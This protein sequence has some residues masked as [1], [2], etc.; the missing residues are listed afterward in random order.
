MYWTTA[1]GSIRRAGMDGSNQIMIADTGVRELRG[2]TIDFQSSRL[3][4]VSANGK[5]IQP[6]SMNGGSV[7]T[8]LSLPG[9][10]WPIGIGIFGDRIYWTDHNSNF[11]KSCTKSGQDVQILHSGGGSPRHL[12]I[13]PALH[14]PTARIKDC[15]NLSCTKVCVLSPTSSGCLA[16]SVPI[17]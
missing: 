10:S 1:G 8:I 2:I 17:F 14:P 12:A 11:L 16:Q 3:L 13:I 7:Q 15:E 6:S 5:K 9:G 4:W